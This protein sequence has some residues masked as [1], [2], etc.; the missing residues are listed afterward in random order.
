[1][2]KSLLIFEDVFFAR[3]QPGLLPRGEGEIAGRF[4]ENIV[5][6]GEL[7]ALNVR[8]AR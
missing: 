2:G 8:A 7:S 1:L 4:R 3:P 6:P 5:V